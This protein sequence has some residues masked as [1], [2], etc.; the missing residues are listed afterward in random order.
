MEH[1][2][3]KHCKIEPHLHTDPSVSVRTYSDNLQTNFSDQR[4]DFEFTVAWWRILW[5]KNFRIWIFFCLR[6]WFLKEFST[7]ARMW[8]WSGWFIDLRKRV[9]KSLICVFRVAFWS[10]RTE[11]SL[12][13]GLCWLG[14]ILGH[15]ALSVK[16][17]EKYHEACISL[18]K[19]YDGSLSQLNLDA[20]KFPELWIYLPIYLSI[21]LA[22]YLSIYLSTTC[23]SIYLLIY[24]LVPIYLQHFC[25]TLAA[26][27]SFLIFFIESVW[28]FGLGISSWQGRYRHNT[29]Q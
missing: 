1:V 16:P 14:A 13:R 19:W 2:Q 3:I 10:G 20:I 27:L 12:L 7:V 11:S 6:K 15:G 26:Y 29:G 5:T 22:I 4:I 25:W 21:Y 8:S 24:L 28:I 23:L 17:L 9:S 18:E